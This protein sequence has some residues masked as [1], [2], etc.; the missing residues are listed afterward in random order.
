M[1]RKEIDQKLE[2]I[3]AR[4]TS[5]KV[6]SS[7]E[8][9]EIESTLNTILEVE[10]TNSEALYW[11]AYL[12]MKDKNYKSALENFEKTL[13]LEKDS[14]MRELIQDNIDICKMLV[15]YEY[16]DKRNSG[17]KIENILGKAPDMLGKVSPIALFITKIVILLVAIL[18]FC[19]SLIFS[20]NDRKILNDT[21][22]YK[23]QKE[24]ELAQKTQKLR[25][26]ATNSNKTSKTTGNY[27]N[28]TV[29]PLSSLNFLTKKQI[30][31]LRKYYVQKSLFASKDYEPNAEVFGRIAD[32][33]PWWT[34]KPC[35]PLNYEGDYHERIQG[36][37]KVSAQ[38]NNPNALV[39]ISMAYSPWE[40]ED[41]TEFC[42]SKS[43]EFLPER[44]SYSPKENLIVAEYKVPSYFHRLKSK[45]NGKIM[46]YPLQLSGMNAIDFGYNY[47]Y[48]YEAKNIG[49]MNPES[50][51]MTMDVQIFRDY[52]HLGG[53]CKYKDGC[54]NI[55]PLQ[56]N[57]MF[58]VDNL[59]AIITLKLWKKQ[60][61]NKYVKGDIYYK[62]LITD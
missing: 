48:A 60:P 50:S 44:M 18:I 36:D 23:M 39:G 32:G 47:V 7:E 1:D 29:N 37:S 15:D 2:D 4:M 21:N 3:S 6:F 12:Y 59:P 54:N 9:D 35:T 53:S 42:N 14:T 27:T 19:P 58:A 25:T 55:S 57:L 26:N 5:S 8:K 43:A 51:N 34:S 40:Y 61:I 38:L 16:G 41:N 20:Y 62:I 28:L 49:M 52:I 45:V 17:D 24:T 31:E 56:T 30:Y 22:Y 46:G 13:E 33:K 11:I 10:P